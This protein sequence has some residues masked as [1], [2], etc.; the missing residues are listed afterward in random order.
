M[1]RSFTTTLLA[2]GMFMASVAAQPPADAALEIQAISS[3]A[4]LV[5]GGDV[6]LQVTGPSNLTARNLT[7]RLNGSDVSRSFRL[8]AD[9]RSVVGRVSGLDVGPNAIEASMRG[10]T[11]AQLT[12]VNHPITGPVLY[13][14]Q[15]MPFVCET[16]AH[17]LGTPLDAN[18]SADTK[19]EYFYKV[20]ETPAPANQA[21]G[22][23]ASA[24]NANGF[25]GGAQESPFRPFDPDGPRPA[26]PIPC[27][28]Y[29]GRAGTGP[30]AS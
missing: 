1:A 18:C 12:V 8:A 19:V 14:P 5:S 6:L 26:N 27:L 22:D 25:R 29:V 11:T 3:K 20:D 24:D 9:S 21:P 17:G 13:S 15:Q 4:E 23:L 7:V 10:Q 2:V 28:E 16:E 30:P